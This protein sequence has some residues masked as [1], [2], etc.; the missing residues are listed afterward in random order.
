MGDCDGDT[1]SRV[2]P[3]SRDTN[4]EQRSYEV[5]AHH[6]WAEACQGLD[7]CH[8]G[9]GPCVC[10]VTSKENKS[11]G[12]PILM[13]IFFRVSAFKTDAKV[14]APN[15]SVT[16]ALQIQNRGNFWFFLINRRI[17]WSHRDLV[18]FVIYG[19]SIFSLGFIPVR[20]GQLARYRPCWL[21]YYVLPNWT[22]NFVWLILQFFTL[23]LTHFDINEQ[24]VFL[25]KFDSDCPRYI[26]K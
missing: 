17:V 22:L 21:I 2:V 19:H 1:G 26:T 14:K 3:I 16:Q 4:Q 25:Q 13:I 5:F 6:R 12:Q 15:L 7:P 10:F 20:P 11:R 9:T 24:L 23:I 8:C 18:T